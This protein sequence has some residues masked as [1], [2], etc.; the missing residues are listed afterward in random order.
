MSVDVAYEV[1]HL[2]AGI[3]PALSEPVIEACDHTAPLERG[4]ALP[5]RRYFARHF[6]GRI[7]GRRDIDLEGAF[8]KNVVAPMFVDECGPGFPRFPHIV[9]RRKL[10]E[11]QRHRG[12][13]ILGLRPGRRHAHGDEFSDVTHFAGRQDTLLRYL[14][15]AQAGYGA[16]RLYPRQIRGREHDIAITLRHV[17]GL[18]PGVR[19]RAADEGDILKTCEPDIGHVLAAS[20]HEAIVFLARKPSPDP[21]SE[22]GCQ[23]GRMMAISVRL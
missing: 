9:D 13:D 17:D 7:E 1:V 5:R 2:G 19:Q 20:A 3:K 15:P 21:L 4:H 6:N 14:E 16:D 12:R 10:F 11:V 22:L 8:E 18:Y 23:V